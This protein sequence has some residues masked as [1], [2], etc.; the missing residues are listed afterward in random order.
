M[1]DR[2][3]SRVCSHWGHTRALTR[4]VCNSLP[5]TRRMRDRSFVW[6]R[7]STRLTLVVVETVLLFFSAT[8]L[9]VTRR[10]RQQIR[11]GD[12]GKLHFTGWRTELSNN[13][14]R[15]DSDNKN[16]KTC[17]AIRYPSPKSWS[18]SPEPVSRTS[19]RDHHHLWVTAVLS[20][21]R[22]TR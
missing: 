1:P 17:G 13:T 14:Y 19:F 12:G 3:R 6:I 20:C 7:E 11:N 16:N 8:S 21:R 9:P 22:S 4:L 15:C 5:I 2:L 10:P 18:P